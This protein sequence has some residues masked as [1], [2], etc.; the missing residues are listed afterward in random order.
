MSKRET[1][2]GRGVERSRLQVEKR[3]SRGRR[4]RL[5]GRV[6]AGSEPDQS[7]VR[8]IARPLGVA[9]VE[10][11][12]DRFP[13][14]RCSFPGGAQCADAGAA[15]QFLQIQAAENRGSPLD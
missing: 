1:R 3:D 6:E 15:R 5:G 2:R 14:L 9:R 10:D 12:Q 11:G 7:G 13:G 4:F 8:R